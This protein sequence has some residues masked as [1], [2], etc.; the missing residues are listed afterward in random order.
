MQ[1]PNPTEYI[2]AYVKRSLE[3]TG[4]FTSEDADYLYGKVKSK[5]Q[6]TIYGVPT[7]ARFNKIISL[8]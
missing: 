4:T 3:V 5:Y 7:R 8:L 6:G 1:N 2:Q